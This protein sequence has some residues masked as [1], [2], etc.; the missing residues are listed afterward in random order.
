MSRIFSYKVG[1]LLLCA[2]CVIL[3][4]CTGSQNQATTQAPATKQASSPA[5]GTVPELTIT[6]PAD[7]AVLPAGNITVSVRVSSFRMVPQYGAY[8]PGEGHLHY[9]MDLPSIAPPEN[10]PPGSFVP[11]TDTSYTW[12][13]VPAGT[14]TFTV[15][16]ASSDHTPLPQPVKRT[17]TVTVTGRVP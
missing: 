4:G 17:V 13:N 5:S 1:I 3:A 11:T 7:G 10:L 8:V 15:E 9:Y 14:H 6:A 2:A 12:A 16:L